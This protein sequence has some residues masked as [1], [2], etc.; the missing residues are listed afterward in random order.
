MKMKINF[1]ATDPTNFSYPE[2]V[3]EKLQLLSTIFEFEIRDVQQSE[4]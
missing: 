1:E 4:C 3:L 2:S